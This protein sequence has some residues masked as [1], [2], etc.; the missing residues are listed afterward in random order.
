MNYLIVSKMNVEAVKAQM[1]EDIESL[2]YDTDDDQQIQME[3][4][5]FSE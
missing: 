1:L 3:I 4:L 2:E 5:D